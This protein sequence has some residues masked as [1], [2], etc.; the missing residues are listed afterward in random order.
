VYDYNA[1][2]PEA[3][4]TA[5]AVWDVMQRAS[6]KAIRLIKQKDFQKYLTV[7]NPA[8]GEEFFNQ[9]CSL[10]LFLFQCQK[11]LYCDLLFSDLT[12]CA[13]DQSPLQFSQQARNVN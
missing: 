9:V 13:P 5:T 4:R 3:D 11:F 10:F 1:R 6:D 8:N 2:T 12:S 7:A